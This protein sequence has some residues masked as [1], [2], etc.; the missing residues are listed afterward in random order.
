MSSHEE[1]RL[2]P[3]EAICAGMA[4]FTSVTEASANLSLLAY[5]RI[6]ERAWDDF[7]LTGVLCVDHIPAVYFK[8][9]SA[10][11]SDEELNDLHRRF[12]NQ[13]VAQTLVVADPKTVRIFSGLAEPQKPETPLT[14]D[15]P[16]LVETISRI[17]FAQNVTSFCQASAN[18]SWYIQHASHYKTD[19]SVDT[20]LLANL[21]D[22]H[23]LLTKENKEFVIEAQTAN[24]LIGRVLFVCYLVDRNIHELPSSFANKSLNQALK[25]ILDDNAAIN[26][27]YGLFEELKDK[28]NG[29]MFD[30][31]LSK[32]KE[33]IKPF[34]IRQIRDFLDGQKIGSSLRNLGFWAYD[35]KLIPVETISAIYEEF[36]AHE[37]PNRKRETG[38]FY[39]PR[40][41]AEMTIDVA[42]E[43]RDDW[44]TLRYLDPCC[45]SGI[46]LVTLFNRLATK[47]WL[48]NPDCDTDPDGYLKKV[49]ALREILSH[50][51]RGVDL[52]PTACQLAC[53]SLYIAFMD[54]LRPSDIWTYMDKTRRKLPRL[55]VDAGVTPGPDCIPVIRQAN[56]LETTSL[57]AESFDCVIGNPPWEGIGSKQIAIHILEH[58]E[59]YLTSDGE[60]CQLLPSK[61]FLNSQ[62]NNFQARWLKRVTVERV[63]QLADY[64]F[65][66]FEQ[67]LCPAM[68]VR[69]RKR[70]MNDPSHRIAYDTPKFH[71]SARRRGLISIGSQ[72]HKWLSQLELVEAARKDAANIIW[73][74][75]FWGTSRDMRLIS[76]LETLPALSLITG[77]PDSN[78]RW[79]RGKGF[80]PDTNKRCSLP[81]FPW[82]S[83]EALYLPSRSE[84]FKA[85]S[86]LFK[87]DCEEVGERYKELRRP[88]MRAGHP[89]VIIN[90]GFANV[91][92]ADFELIFRNSIHFISGPKEDEDLLLFL[93]IYL[94]SNL[95]KYVMFH[96]A[97]N[98][99]TERDKVHLEE[100]L[101]LPFPLPEDAPAEHAA[102]IV[103]HVANRMQQEQTAQEK[104]YDECLGQHHNLAGPDNQRA[105]KEWLKQRRER[106]GALQAE[107]EPLIYEYFGLYGPEVMLLEDTVN[108][109]IPSS[110]PPNPDRLNLPTL[111]SV[112]ARKVPGYQKGLAVYAETL[113]E[114]L[115]SWAADRSSEFR[116]RPSGGVD[117]KAGVAMVSLLLRKDAGS[118]SSLDISGE[119]SHWLKRGLEACASQTPTILSE[120]E[121][122]WFE[123][124]YIYIIKPSTLTYWTRTAALN[125]ADTIYGEIS[126]ARRNA[127]A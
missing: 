78:A 115:N 65:I 42:V 95:A 100:L 103:R 38:A 17:E 68:I 6:I 109:S 82:W 84:S 19:S 20:Y 94:R 41:L 123:G 14:S 121:L 62:T 8:N 122:L 7:G 119:L 18:G 87:S 110:T 31:D 71:P 126:Q 30:Q 5:I 67:A 111:Q 79:T 99:G 127:N 97:A 26:F 35:F 10:P 4:Y 96:T 69:Y 86:I 27:L 77:L 52:H 45:G 60:G 13:G 46:F 29:S 116:V 12:W 59:R 76:Y 81:H 105:R 66:L 93:T 106:T 1:T 114:T 90:Y 80:E 88:A 15:S 107:L 55:L 9:V 56:F 33:Q 37:D 25:E 53:F 3:S 64:S 113:S 72:D 83:D 57:A 73:K 120:R 34:H 58:A 51:I 70:T 47:W 124:D 2:V 44:H 48:D 102:D 43:G 61:V 39:T 91:A 36:L 118:M 22:L 101:M 75:L 16:S 104:L 98:W 49:E 54:C 74:R 32:E 11:L 112:S 63:V 108:I 40:F 89:V 23:N 28:F 92:F 24:A 85:G 117:E 21:V 50:N 125:D